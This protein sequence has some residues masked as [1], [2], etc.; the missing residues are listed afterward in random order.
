[1]MAM[2]M[3]PIDM[4]LPLRAVSGWLRYLRPKMKSPAAVM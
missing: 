4:R 2:S 3:A 1:M